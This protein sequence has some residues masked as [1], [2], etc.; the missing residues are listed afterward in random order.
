MGSRDHRGHRLVECQRILA[1]PRLRTQQTRRIQPVGADIERELS[2]IGA[3]HWPERSG[4][5]VCGL[6]ARLPSTLLCPSLA[7]WRKVLCKRHQHDGGS[8]VDASGLYPGR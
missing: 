3:R 1:H 4:Q 5:R 6:D 2:I 8:R 7:C